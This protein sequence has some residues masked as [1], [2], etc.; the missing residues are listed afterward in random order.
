MRW[1]AALAT[2]ALLAGCSAAPAQS[3]P[4]PTATVTVFAASSLT[5]PLTELARTYEASHPGV[6][7]RLS[8][9]A[10][11]TLA[12][13][14]TEGASADL[15]L[16]AGTTVLDRLPENYRGAA[17]TTVAHNVLAIATQSGNPHAIT[18]LAGL[19]DPTLDVVLCATTV[20][21]GAAAD[22][23]LARAKVTPHVVSREVDVKATLAKVSLGEADAA[24]VYHSDVV[25]SRGSVTGIDIPAA[26]NVRLAYPLVQLTTTPAAAAL[27]TYL[28]GPDARAA[29]T[30]A[31]FSP[32]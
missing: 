21:C 11:S 19:A 7:I 16:T 28:H 31:G 2:T 15:L 24:L 29:L 10:S 6:T 9:G 27:A 13:Q 5:K 12:Q 22:T 1:L 20:P 17:R 23:I 8:F 26:L 18:G 25:G 14:V 30:R 4:T 3:P 32:P